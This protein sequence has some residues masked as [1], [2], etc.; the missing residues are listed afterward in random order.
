MNY[1]LPSFLL[2]YYIVFPVA[3]AEVDPNIEAASQFPFSEMLTPL[4]E[5]P[6]L[7]EAK[8]G[9]H[10]VNVRT[11]EEVFSFR[12]DEPLVPASVMK[13]ITSA[14][15]IRNLGPDFRF[16]TKLY[17]DGEI[18]SEGTLN[19]DLY[20]KGGGD[21]SLTVQ[22][23][24]KLV[25]DAKTMGLNK[26]AGNV[27][28]DNSLYGGVNY[29]PGWEKSVDMLNGPSYF[30]L[31]SAL[32]LNT[33]AVAIKVKP[34]ESVGSQA[35]VFFDFPAPFLQIENHVT[36]SKKRSR[37]K[38][39]ITRK[40]ENETVIFRLEGQIPISEERAWTYYRTHPY[41]DQFFMHYFAAMLKQ[42]KIKVSK[43]HRFK[44]TPS[45]LPQYHRHKSEPLRKMI[46]D[47][48]KHSRNLW[49][50]HFLI[51]LG[52]QA[53]KGPATT[54]DGVVAVENYLKK[55]GVY[56]EDTVLVNG[57]GLSRE[58]KIPASTVSAV[59]LDMKSNQAIGLEFLSS[60]AVAG[61]MGT[62]R[63][64]FQED[65]YAGRVRGKTG[66]LN[67]VYCLSVF[68]WGEKDLYVMT[69][70]GNNLSKPS[71]YTRKVQNFIIKTLLDGKTATEEE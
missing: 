49:A 69:F 35:N 56:S 44:K 57:S 53:K 27:F 40:V 70:L 28:Y 17:I 54:A 9:V 36:T 4:L 25:Y 14:V 29:I 71:S 62:L 61:G 65:S 38:M 5:D 64:R 63:Y 47:L 33:N 23:L 12:G 59:L 6:L 48:N 31:L 22:N 68:V 1:L 26:I 20:V 43:K 42:H 7:E 45:R 11:G 2:F 60:M 66:S 58:I 10:V 19:G 67:G 18:D 41:P 52:V 16:R 8:I 30:P 24:W 15:A 37:R 13:V 51:Q 39:R 34:G 21:P 46:M 3:I 55:I 32:S 50:E